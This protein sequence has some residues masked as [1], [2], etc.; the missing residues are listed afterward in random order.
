MSWQCAAHLFALVQEDDEDMLALE[1]P[2][3]LHGQVTFTAVRN[4]FK[5]CAY[6][7]PLHASC[8]A[9]SSHKRWHGLADQPRMCAHLLQKLLEHV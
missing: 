1:L 4:N 3:C 5:R 8:Q 2:A 6:L 9:G 7:Q